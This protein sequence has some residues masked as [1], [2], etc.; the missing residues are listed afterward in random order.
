MAIFISPLARAV[1]EAIVLFLEVVELSLATLNASVS[2]A[3]V[4]SDQRAFECDLCEYKGKTANHLRQHKQK[5]HEN[6]RPH[7]CDCCGK[8]FYR[9]IEQLPFKIFDRSFIL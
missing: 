9:F 7:I 8:R 1:L 6:Y 5:V 4:H 2:L 3:S